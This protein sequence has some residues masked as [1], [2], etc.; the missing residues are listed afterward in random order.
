MPWVIMFAN[1][2]QKEKMRILL[3]DDHALFRKGMHYMLKSLDD[4]LILDEAS[5]TKEA[6]A[7]LA[8]GTFDLILLDLKLPDSRGLDTLKALRNVNS[9]VPF[10]VISAEDDPNAIRATVEHGAMG[11]IP[12]SSSHEVLIQAL[13]LV[14]AKGIYL[15]PDLLKTNYLSGFPQP[16]DSTDSWESIVLKGLTERQMEVL[17]GV[18]KGKS[19]RAIGEELSLSDATVKAHLT[20]T[21]RALGVGSRTEAIFAAA[22]L[23]L[24]VP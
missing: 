4:S 6:T 7:I 12:K 24:R 23:G 10:V 11:F 13:R 14:L 22:Q 16:L 19:N 18:I 17:R 20:A 9:D 15:P 5:S 1:L 2:K 8:A 21:Y 3:V